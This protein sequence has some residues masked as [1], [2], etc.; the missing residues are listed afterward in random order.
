MDPPDERPTRLQHYLRPALTVKDVGSHVKAAIAILPTFFVTVL[1]GCRTR[2]PPSQLYT[3]IVAR[4][5]N[6]SGWA[7]SI[8]GLLEPV[9]SREPTGVRSDV[10]DWQCK[11]VPGIEFAVSL[12]TS[13]CDSIQMNSAS[14]DD[15]KPCR[16]CMV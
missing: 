2:G 10:T 3:E 1:I 14:V 8:S 6:R 13:E 5:S 12:L 11:V 7:I 9:A 16:P 4:D 15:L